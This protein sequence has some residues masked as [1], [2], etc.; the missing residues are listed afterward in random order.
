MN[1]VIGTISAE[2]PPACSDSCRGQ[3]L[4][5]TASP[6]RI[7]SKI[8]SGTVSDGR[9]GTA[10]EVRGCYRVHGVATRSLTTAATCRWTA[11]SSR[12]RSSTAFVPG[13][14]LRLRSGPG[15]RTRR[16]I[17][18]GRLMIHRNR[19]PPTVS[20][21]QKAMAILPFRRGRNRDHEPPIRRRPIWA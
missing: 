13:S 19:I 11:W 4:G 3:R 1:T 17:R 6:T 5:A 7:T 16:Q 12:M 8:T 18:E 15:S 21:S 14:S 2:V 9:L 20:L 10:E